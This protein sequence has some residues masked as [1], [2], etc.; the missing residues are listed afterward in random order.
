MQSE[1]EHSRPP[2]LIQGHGQILVRLLRVRD[3]I[4]CEQPIENGSKG[5]AEATSC[6][7]LNHPSSRLDLRHRSRPWPPV[8]AIRHGAS[9]IGYAHSRIPHGRQRIGG[10]ILHVILPSRLSPHSPSIFR[11]SACTP[12]SAG[13]SRCARRCKSG[14]RPPRR[15]PKPKRGRMTG[16]NLNPDSRNGAR[17][18][19]RLMRACGWRSIVRSLPSAS[20][21]LARRA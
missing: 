10:G 9:R 2:R 18:M 14:L 3:D 19:L 8:A 21:P 12:G 1:G 6:R 20:Q 16:R 4:P 13:P 11:R 5:E 17:G 7:F 15:T